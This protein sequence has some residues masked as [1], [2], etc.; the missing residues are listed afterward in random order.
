MLR[1]TTSGPTLLTTAPLAN[2]SE[3][4][5]SL[6]R[7]SGAGA[8]KRGRAA[9]MTTGLREEPT[10]PGERPSS[11]PAAVQHFFNFQLH[12][13]HQ[14]IILL[15]SAIHSLLCKSPF[16]FNKCAIFRPIS[17]LS[18]SPDPASTNQTNN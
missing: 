13:T 11:L 6:E 4:I 9:D 16:S 3:S 2:P 8:G 15:I 10:S 17:E 7:D 14:I 5:G 18:S 12:V 1:S